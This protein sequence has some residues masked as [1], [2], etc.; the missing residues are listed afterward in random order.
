[1]KVEFKNNE[2]GRV[3]VVNGVEVGRIV[4]NVVSLDIYSPQ[5]TESGDRIDLG[6]AGSLMYSRANMGN[7][8]VE[9]IGH[10]HDGLRELIS[11][12]IILSGEVNDDEL[13]L[14]VLNVLRQYMDKELLRM[15]EQHS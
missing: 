4:D 11:V 13:S 1:M 12:R 9:L 8:V 7:H 15:I 6:W 14:M 5:F 2:W 10:E 3:I